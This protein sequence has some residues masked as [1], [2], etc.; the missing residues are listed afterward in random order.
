M[1]SFGTTMTMANDRDPNR[2]PRASSPRDT[3]APPQTNIRPDTRSPILSQR[4]LRQLG[5]FFAGAGFLSLATLVTRRA[6]VRKQR[7]TIPRFYQPSNGP[8]S[9]IDS[10]GSFIAVEALGLATLNVISFGIMATGGLAWAFD[11]SNIGDLRQL[12]RKSIGG[13]GGGR[14]DEEAER[15][16]EEW[17]AKVLLRRDDIDK[18]KA[19]KPPFHKGE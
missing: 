2:E 16:V 19:T 13:E 17:V 14:T 3:I 4:S 9:K 8:V 11:I 6:V 7:A 18:E 10:D 5:L 15:D 12:A 1:W